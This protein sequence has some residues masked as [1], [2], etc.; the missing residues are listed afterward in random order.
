[1][2]QYADGKGNGAVNLL[3]TSKG[4][5]DTHSGDYQ[6]YIDKYAGGSVGG[7][8]GKGGNF[9]NYYEK[10]MKRY[11]NQEQNNVVASAH[12]AT[13]ISALDAWKSAAEQ[14]NKWYVPAAYASYANKNV[15]RQYKERLNELEHPA[16]A[17]A[18]STP[19]DDETMLDAKADKG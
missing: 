18:S 17:G 19:F 12:D 4:S 7:K 5:S 10:Y 1:M 11:N 3:E 8:D 15:E 2:H 13:N 14:N 9:K 6:Q 16:K